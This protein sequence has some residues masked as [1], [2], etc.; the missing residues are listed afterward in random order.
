MCPSAHQP[1]PRRDKASVNTLKLFTE[2][3]L[4]AALMQS[5]TK[6]SV[7]AENI[8]QTDKEVQ[9]QLKSAV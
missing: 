7:P 6:T 4:H 1:P 2:P 8:L 9:V 5:C 3:P